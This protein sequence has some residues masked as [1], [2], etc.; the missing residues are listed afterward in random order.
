MLVDAASWWLSWYF[1]K[2]CRLK[3]VRHICIQGTTTDAI[4]SKESEEIMTAYFQ[5]KDKTQAELFST[6]R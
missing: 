5:T 1:A 4:L 2:A 6:R 3:L